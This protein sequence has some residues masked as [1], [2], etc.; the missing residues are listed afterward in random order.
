MLN[1][2]NNN[3]MLYR[4]SQKKKKYD[5]NEI[6]KTHALKKIIPVPTKDGG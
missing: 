6:I 1:N 2:N 4:N 5:N 3:E